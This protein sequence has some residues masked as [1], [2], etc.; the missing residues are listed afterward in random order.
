MTSSEVWDQDTA[1]RYDADSSEMFSADILDPA[2]D[3]LA[4]LAGDGP[5]LEFAVGTGRVALPLAARGVPV[6]GIELS[7]PMAEQLRRKA[8][9]EQ[10]PVVVGDM[11]TSTVAG[12]FSL[13]FLVWNSLSNL[14]T[15]GRA[16]GVLRQRCPTSQFG[17]AFRRR[18]VGARATAAP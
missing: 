16:G 9:G 14:L 3:F 1:G 4:A 13:V 12:Q 7:A 17:W 15:P 5:A 18:T 2:V 6:S 11:A 8:G 10:I